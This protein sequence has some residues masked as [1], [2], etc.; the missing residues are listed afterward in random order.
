MGSFH[1]TTPR[2]QPSLREAE[3][4][5]QGKTLEAGTAAENKE[6]HWLLTC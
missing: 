1:L 5:T 2:S 6:E 3:A 4:G